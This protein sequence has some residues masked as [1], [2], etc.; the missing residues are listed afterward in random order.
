MKFHHHH[1]IKQNGR[2][3][4]F[5]EEQILKFNANLTHF[6]F[7]FR[8]VILNFFTNLTAVACNSFGD[9]VFDFLG[10]LFCYISFG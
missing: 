6:V 2:A 7:C 10:F 8:N 5:H 9:G 1:K 3:D 4:H